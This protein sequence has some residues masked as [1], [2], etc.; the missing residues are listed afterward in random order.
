[1]PKIISSVHHV[2]FV[3][4]VLV[5]PGYGFFLSLVDG[6]QFVLC[7]PQHLRRYCTNSRPCVSPSDQYVTILCDVCVCQ[8][9]NM[10]CFPAL[11]I[12]E[13]I[14]DVGVGLAAEV[15]PDRGG[16]FFLSPAS[17]R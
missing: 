6:K 15:S 2:W 9:V 4:H 14:S 7:F 1:M 10:F 13:A 11:M 16:T 5:E 8:H 3:R 12:W 17:V